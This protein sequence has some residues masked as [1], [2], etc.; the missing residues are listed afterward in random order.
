MMNEQK[1]ILNTE[2]AALKNNYC[3]FLK[4][5]D[6]FGITF[7]FRIDRQEKFQSTSGG[8]WLISFLILFIILYFQAIKN[9]FKYPEYTYYSYEN[10]LVLKDSKE[11][12][13]LQNEKFDFGVSLNYNK[14]LFPINP[15]IINGYYIELN[16]KTNFT[17]NR[18][19]LNKVKCDPIK[20]SSK[21]YL[22][23]NVTKEKLNSMVCFNQN[24]KTIGGSEFVDKIYYFNVEISINPALNSS[25]VLE[26]IHDTNSIFNLIYTDIDVDFND[27]SK[28]EIEPNR[29]FNGI[30]NDQLNIIDFYV[31]RHEY[32]QDLGF[33]M[34]NIET[35]RYAK[36]FAT[37]LR[38]TEMISNNGN[39]VKV[40]I[41]NIFGVNSYKFTQK[42]IGKF[43]TSMQLQM[44]H[45]L[46][47][48][49]I[50]KII[51][52]MI[53]NKLGKE[54]LINK[55]FE[56][57]FEFL[58][59]L[60][61][62]N[63]SLNQNVNLDNIQKKNENNNSSKIISENANNDLLNKNSLKEACE[64]TNRNNYQ[65]LQ[66]VSNTSIFPETNRNFIGKNVEIS[67]Q[68]S[69][70]KDYIINPNNSTFNKII[71]QNNDLILDSKNINQ[72]NVKIINK[73]N[74]NEKYNEFDQILDLSNFVRKN[75]E[76]DLLKYLLL[77]E[78]TI[79]LFNFLT[80][81]VNLFDD[82]QNKNVFHER[83]IQE[84]LKQNISNVKNCNPTEIYKKKINTLFEKL[85]KN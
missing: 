41:I 19:E 14:N 15:F 76:I 84:L 67:N 3:D 51:A 75:H 5:L 50:F 65:I 57:D 82:K 70:N 32:Q 39:L 16:S 9:Y 59:E 10:S 20:F 25:R 45:L 33:I 47:Y 55:I 11:Y 35:F 8:F 62:L 23:S 53:N 63:D 64:I 54:K 44:T 21:Y 36:H 56:Q 31:S 13:N 48:L 78:N 60:Y 17:E 40:G 74:L 1:K 4:H 79:Y 34:E 61:L 29:I 72:N 22:K 85:L 58:K 12:L 26:L 2:T 27:Y 42:Y 24:Y 81:K 77:D 52:T 30:Q 28:I 7:N 46:N 6:I 38:S 66:K 73:I 83:E 68:D 69:K 49:V 71:N 43:V 37:S 80:G 18:T